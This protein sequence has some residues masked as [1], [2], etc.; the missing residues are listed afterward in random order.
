[1]GLIGDIRAS[2]GL[3]RSSRRDGRG[4]RVAGVRRNASGVR[5][6]ATLRELRDLLDNH[7][8][9]GVVS[10]NALAIAVGVTDTTV[11]R[12]LRGVDVPTIETQRA[13]RAWVRARLR[14][15]VST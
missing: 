2:D 10:A 9:R 1:M 8:K 3:P 6:E 13:V 4:G 11:G 5:W 12:W 7:A 14:G 15:L